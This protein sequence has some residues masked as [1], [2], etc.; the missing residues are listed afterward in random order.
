MSFSTTF[1]ILAISF[2][3]TPAFLPFAISIISSFS[4]LVSFSG[5]SLFNV[6][7]FKSF[8]RL[9]SSAVYEFLAILISSG[10]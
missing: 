6:R 2:K 8:K 7:L 1:A 10:K 3:V 4:S 5:D 9:K